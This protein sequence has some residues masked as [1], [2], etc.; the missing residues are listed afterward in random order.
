MIKIIDDFLPSDEAITL[1]N[2]FFETASWKPYWNTGV[3]KSEKKAWNW[4]TLIGN[5]DQNMFGTSY[6]NVNSSNPP[7]E[8]DHLCETA[9]E[10][11]QKTTS[12]K[13]NIDRLYSNSHTY[14]MEGPIHRDDGSLT[15]LYYPCQRWKID[16]EG[17]TSFY[18]EKVDDVIKYAAYKFNRAVIFDAK[19]PHRAM[20]TTRDCYSL[21]TSIAFKTSMDVTDPSYSKWYAEKLKDF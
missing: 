6:D 16:W 3:S 21:R 11:C 20:P 14:G 2:M 13:H 15:V 5:D 17:G 9:E 18:N 1:S 8:F 4:H 19:I 12:V 10:W 7:A